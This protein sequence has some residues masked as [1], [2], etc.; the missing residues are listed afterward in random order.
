[1]M[2]L[3][4]I[5]IPLSPILHLDAFVSIPLVGTWVGIFLSKYTILQ[6]KLKQGENINQST[7]R[8]IVCD[9]D[10]LLQSLF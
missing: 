5:L 9:I 8:E 10:A 1:M 2:V 6:F 7:F 3:C 4:G